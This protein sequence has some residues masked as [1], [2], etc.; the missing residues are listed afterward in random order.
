MLYNVCE[1]WQRLQACQAPAGSQWLIAKLAMLGLQLTCKSD[2][3]LDMPGGFAVAR[4]GGCA[5]KAYHSIQAGTQPWQLALEHLLHVD[6]GGPARW[7][8]D[9]YSVIT[10]SGAVILDHHSRP[11]CHGVQTMTVHP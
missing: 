4:S 3:V 6:T 10:K 5:A 1:A 2:V 7:C 8:H 11:N 9:M